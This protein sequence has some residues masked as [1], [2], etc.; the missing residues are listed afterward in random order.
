[1]GSIADKLTYLNTTKTLLREGIN[2]IGGNILPTDTFRSYA[3]YLNRMYDKLPKVSGTGTTI[4]L[5][6]TDKGRLATDLKG[7]TYQE[8]TIG[9]NL[10]KFNART[11]STYGYTCDET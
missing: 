10:Q 8:T 6:D 5:N 11:S 7:N 9:A 2:S 1:M 4:S 3:L